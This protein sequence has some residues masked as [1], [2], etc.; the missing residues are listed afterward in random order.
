MGNSVSGVRPER[1][2]PASRSL[3][4]LCCQVRLKRFQHCRLSVLTTKEPNIHAK[5]LR[6]LQNKVPFIMKV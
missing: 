2:C 3:A 4:V 1:T 6:N 5:D